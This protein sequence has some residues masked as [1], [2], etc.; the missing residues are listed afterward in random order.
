MTDVTQLSDEFLLQSSL[1][2]ESVVDV[3]K[4]KKLVV[5]PDLQ[6]GSY[7][8]GTVTYDATATAGS[9]GY[10]SLKDAY[11]TV[12]YV[13]SA[14]S[15]GGTDITSGLKR[16][17][18][19][20]KCN[21]TNIVDSLSL[22]MNGQT[23][24]A[25]GEYR[26]F[27]NNL[28]AQT[29]RSQNDIT[30]H[31]AD[32]YLYPDDW[33]SINFSASASGAGDSYS[34]NQVDNAA[35]LDTTLAQSQENR[36]FNNGLFNRLCSMLPTV[37]STDAV[38]SWSWPSLGT[39]ATRNIV[40]QNAKGCFKESDTTIISATKVLGRWIYMLKIRLVDLHPIFKELN[41]VS[42]PQFK[43]RIRFNTGTVKVSGTATTMQL[44]SV[45]MTSGQT[46]PIMVSSAAA[47]QPM[48]GVLSTGAQVGFGVLQNEYTSVAEVG[49][50]VPYTTTRLN[51]PF[52]ELR[53][54]SSIINKPI[55]HIRFNDVYAQY[56]TKRAGETPDTIT[57]QLNVDFNFQ[58]S[59]TFKNIKYVALLPFAET[60][61]SHFASAH[62]TQQFQSPFDSAPWTVMPGASIRNFQVT[63]GNSNVFSKTHEYDYENFQ[64]EFSK[65]VAV[66][67]DHT[68]EISNG[69][70]DANKW[71]YAHRVMVADCHA[72]LRRM[73]PK[74]SKCL[75]LMVM[76]LV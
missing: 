20:L 46:C 8:S 75:E 73:S 58:L 19:T 32:A 45:T 23:V 53:N 29:E 69:L 22:E 13:V 16:F 3:S 25:D 1:K 49:N 63:I 55:K 54:P 27:W 44:D 57:G 61:K 59:G 18:T 65:L 60:S 74:A 4:G 76:L 7:T 62:G 38:P 42:N 10:A 17:A 40:Q 43:L 52:Y 33:Y 34:N 47:N 6:Q 70:I 9:Q 24:L 12:P 71:A 28:R 2:N 35:N 41:L 48:N 64:D 51:I 14:K 68:R 72:F 11:I 50:Y 39:T 66:N 15:T 21:V 30:K 67:G 56:F 37:D 31:G 5:L 36:A 26:M